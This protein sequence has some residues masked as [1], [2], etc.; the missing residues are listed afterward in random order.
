MPD[1]W[2]LVFADISTSVTFA[3]I[4]AQ[5]YHH[6]QQFYG[7]CQTLEVPLSFTI[8]SCIAAATH[9]LIRYEWRYLEMS[10]IEKW[11]FG[12]DG[13]SEEFFISYLE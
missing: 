5:Q 4:L 7:N 11:H 3:K 10:K 6:L 9:L 1:T 12:T 8:A 2:F 13:K